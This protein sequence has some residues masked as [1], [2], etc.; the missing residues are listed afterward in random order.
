MKAREAR[1]TGRPVTQG[2]DPT[3]NNPSSPK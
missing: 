3:W 1:R 2:I